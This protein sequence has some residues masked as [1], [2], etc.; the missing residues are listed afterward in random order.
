[1]D[2]QHRYN[3][4]VKK[5]TV[6]L[7]LDKIVGKV[8]RQSNGGPVDFLLIIALKEAQAERK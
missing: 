1:M 7:I 3:I 2:W 5:K 8:D 6:L 4:I